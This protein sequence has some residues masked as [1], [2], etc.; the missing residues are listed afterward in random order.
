VRH[1]VVQLTGDPGTLGGDGHLGLRLALLL[2]TGGALLQLREVGAAGA[3]G[4]AE[5]P[6]EREGNRLEDHYQDGAQR[7]LILQGPAEL[8]DGR[9][10]Q[11]ADQ[12]EARSPAG[13]VRGDGIDDH[14]HRE[15]RGRRRDIQDHLC[16]T[17]HCG[18]HQHLLG[19]EAA[20]RDDRAQYDGDR[21]RRGERPALI[22][23]AVDI[24]QAHAGDP[25]Q[26][27]GP[28]AVDPCRV[29]AEEVI[30]AL[31]VTQSREARGVQGST[32]GSIREGRSYSPRWMLPRPRRIVPVFR[33]GLAWP[34]E[35][36]GDR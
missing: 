12:P 35:A 14:Q 8:P 9:R 22:G 15:V 13:T 16:D 20:Q 23:G 11:A 24:A 10:A 19:H 26:D 17:C 7:A 28:E 21:E 30:K 2:Q 32:G 33:Q 18:Q 29:P 36:C 27:D 34:G 3:D 1:H 4:V 6:G 25:E 31:H 5:D